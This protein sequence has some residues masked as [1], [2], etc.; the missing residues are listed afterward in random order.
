MCPQYSNLLFAAAGIFCYSLGMDKDMQLL[1]QNARALGLALNEQQLAHFDVYQNELLLWNAKTNLISEKTAPDIVSRHFLD[2][3]TALPFIS[4]KKA[5]LLDI[6]TGAGFPGLPLKIACPDLRIYLLEANRRKVSFLKHII[7]LLNIQDAQVIHDRVEKA[8]QDT[9][10]RA[11]FNIVIS[12][13]T[14]KMADLLPWSD[15]FLAPEGELIAFKGPSLP[16]ELAQCPRDSFPYNIYEYYQHDI[17]Y[18]F[19]DF[20]RKIIIG[21]RIK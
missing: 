13:A 3:L 14:F 21:K 20:P 16:E 17:N 19:F 15:S 8:L 10:W 2:S 1:Q 5:N 12:R 4:N 9:N 11:F 6:G 18:P 7:R